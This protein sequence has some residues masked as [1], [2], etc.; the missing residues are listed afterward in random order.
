MIAKGNE[1][2]FERRKMARDRKESEHGTTLSLAFS[3]PPSLYPH[4]SPHL[5]PIYLF[6]LLSP[7]ISLSLSLPFSLS[8]SLPLSLSR[9][10]SSSLSLSLCLSHTHTH[11]HTNQKMAASEYPTQK[12][13]QDSQF[14]LFKKYE[15]LK[16]ICHCFKYIQHLAQPGQFVGILAAFVLSSSEHNGVVCDKSA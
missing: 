3:P 4:L 13:L 14:T 8:F 1:H 5:S 6:L 15:M 11:T 10:P 12:C 2:S 7:P 9:Y 16:I